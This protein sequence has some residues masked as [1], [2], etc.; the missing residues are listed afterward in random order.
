VRKFRE[1]DGVTAIIVA[2]SITLLLTFGALILD[3]GGAYLQIAKLQTAA[4]AAVFS[5]GVLLP[6]KADDTLKMNEIINTAKEYAQKNGINNLDDVSVTLGG[7]SSGFYRTL[8]VKIDNTYQLHLAKV[9]G[10]HSV[11]I[12]RDAVITIIP[13]SG[14]KG[15]A[16]IGIDVNELTYAVNTGNTNNIVLKYGGGDGLEGHFGF[17]VLDGS[18]GDANTLLDWMKN[19]YG[20]TL[21]VGYQLPNASGNKASVAKKGV[22]YRLSLCTHYTEYGGCSVEH[23]NVNCPKIIKALVYRSIDSDT[24]EIVGFA[25]FLIESVDNKANIYGS[26]LNMTIDAQS[27]SESAFDAGFNTLK[28]IK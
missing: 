22:D 17:V 9:I 7:L 8:E 25:P 14:L 23:Y 15:V 10:K 6:I 13:V 19:G 4:D 11:N 26:Y 12:N 2:C 1:E 3:M 16:P 18:N 24:V 27:G 5:A 28:L 20:Y 21:N